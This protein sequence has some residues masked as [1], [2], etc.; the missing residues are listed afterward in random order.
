MPHLI[1]VLPVAENW[2]VRAPGLAE[3][4]PF[5]SGAKAEAAARQLAGAAARTGRAAA[6]EIYLRDG[7]LA[8]RIDY[9]A[10]IAA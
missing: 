3:D 6:L 2:I 4:L 1:T 10:A 7:S 9:P 8:G 5:L